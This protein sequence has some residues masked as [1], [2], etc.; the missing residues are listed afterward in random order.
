VGTQSLT[1]AGLSAFIL[2]TS[3]VSFG[4]LYTELALLVYLVCLVYLVGWVLLTRG[5]DTNV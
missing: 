5:K 2:L 4:I 1:L 3:P